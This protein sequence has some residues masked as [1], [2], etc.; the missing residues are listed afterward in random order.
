ME[1]STILKYYMSGFVDSLKLVDKSD[2]LS[3]IAKI[4]YWHG[5]VDAWIG[6]DLESNDYQTGLDIINKIK[7]DYYGK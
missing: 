3:G 6:D 7:K 1:D 5:V 4:A 2:E